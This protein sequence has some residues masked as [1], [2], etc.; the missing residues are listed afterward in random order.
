M[1]STHPQLPYPLLTAAAI[2]ALPEQVFVHPLNPRAIRHTKSLGDAVG[3]THLGVHLVR[4]APGDDS[5]QYHRHHAEEEF[6]YIL[7]GRGLAEIGDD[8]IEVQPGDFMGFAPNSLAHGLTN[9][10]DEDL[11]YLMG[12]T[13]LDYDICDY[14]KVNQRLYRVGEQHKWVDVPP[15][16]ET[17]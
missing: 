17:P 10:F 9:P 8:T 16:T 12:G 2:A 11:V 6:I 14:P 4:L 3:C 1:T 5:T 7:S 15:P 13:R